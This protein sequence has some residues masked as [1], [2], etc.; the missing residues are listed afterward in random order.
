ML[1]HDNAPCHTAVSINEFVEKIIVVPQ[2]PF[3]PEISRCDFFLFSRFNNHLKGCHFE[4]LD[5][6]QMSVT[7]ELKD[8]PAEGFQHCYEQWKHFRYV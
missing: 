3:S 6:I 1:H 7:D 4:T 8:I 5:N 2:R